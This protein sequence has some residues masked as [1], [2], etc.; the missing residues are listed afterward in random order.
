M[1]EFPSDVFPSRVRNLLQDLPQVVGSREEYGALGVLWATSICAPNTKVEI[2]SNYRVGLNLYGAVVAPKGDAKSPALGFTTGPIMKRIEGEISRYNKSFAIWHKRLSVL[3]HDRTKEGREKMENHLM[4]EPKVPWY[5]IITEGTSEGIRD[6]AKKNN[7]WGHPPLIGQFSEELDGWVKSMGKYASGGSKDGGEMGF[8]LKAYDGAM[9]IKANKGEKDSTPKF[10]LCLLGTIQPK[11]F[12]EA[13][14]GKVDNG[15][16][17]RF[18]IV[19]GMGEGLVSVDPY[20]TFNGDIV[21]DYDLFM[22]D[23]YERCHPEVLT[24]TSEAVSLGV[25]MYGWLDSTD[26]SYEAEAKSKWWVH[27]HKVAG[28]LAVIWGRGSV[29]AFVMEK[30]VSLTKYLVLSWCMA[31]KVMNLTD[32]DDVEKRITKALRDRPRSK[33]S[34]SS[35]LSQKLRPSLELA[36]SNMYESGIIE[37]RITKSPNGR[38]VSEI[39]LVS[40]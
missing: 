30:A 6:T 11:V 13:F 28:I 26:R 19:T 14:D 15:L 8:Y 12:Q 21:R 33:S 39:A 38:N 34:L 5:G 9:S 24:L 20:A 23:L 29:D 17:D 22:S 3:K 25:S 1:I 32:V 2:K 10:R 16:L 18:V 37:D 7:E 40:R 36:L 31:F 27:L 4:S 35:K